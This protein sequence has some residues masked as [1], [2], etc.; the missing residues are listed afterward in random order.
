MIK[1]PSKVRFKDGIICL[2]IFQVIQDIRLNLFQKIIKWSESYY[3]C[4]LYVYNFQGYRLETPCGFWF[5]P[6]HP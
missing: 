4:L 6:Y 2:Y 1:F 5:L 3:L